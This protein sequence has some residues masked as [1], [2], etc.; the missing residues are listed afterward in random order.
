MNYIFHHISISS[1]ISKRFAVDFSDRLGKETSLSLSIELHFLE[2][3]VCF[4]LLK[5]N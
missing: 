1:V 2:E 5:I 4:S 3:T